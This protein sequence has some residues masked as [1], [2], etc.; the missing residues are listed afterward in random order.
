MWIETSSACTFPCYYAK[1]HPA[2]VCG[3]KLFAT[4]GTVH[5][6]IVTPCVGVWIETLVLLCFFLSFWVT[7]CVGVWIETSTG[8]FSH[9]Q[10]ISVTPCV[11]VWIETTSSSFFVGCSKSH[12]AWVCGLKL[13]SL[14]SYTPYH[15]TPCVGVWIETAWA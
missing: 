2:W 9:L 12:P 13:Q 15:V 3:L 10:A 6:N 7:P 11:G 5:G 4:A 14:L 1:S 8:L